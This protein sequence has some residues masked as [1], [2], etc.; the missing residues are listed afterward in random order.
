[1]EFI[2]LLGLCWK[3]LKAAEIWMINHLELGQTLDEEEEVAPIFFL[4]AEVSWEPVDK[5]M[6][7]N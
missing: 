3:D 2:R 4:V 6:M 1:M 5:S 7:P